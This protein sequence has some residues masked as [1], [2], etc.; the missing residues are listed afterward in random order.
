MLSIRKVSIKSANYY[1]ELAR[2]DYYLSGGEPPGQWHG[3]GAASLGLEGAVTSAQ[4]ENL[5]QG[6][7]PDGKTALVQNAGQ[8]GGYHERVPGWDLTFSP[9]K[10]VSVCWAMATDDVRRAIERAQDQ[11]VRTAL[12]FMEDFAGFTRRGPGGK[13]CEKAT[14]CYALFE[15]GTS[16]AQEPQLHHHVIC[17]N[18]A[19]RSDGTTGAVRSQAL[20]DFRMAV[21]YI[22]SCELAFLL[23]RDVHLPIK[24]VD[25]WFEIDGVSPEVIDRYSTRR[26]EVVAYC[27]ERGKYGAVEAQEAAIATRKPKEHIARDVL[28]RQWQANGEELGWGQEQMMKL[29]QGPGIVRDRT[30]EMAL[31]TQ[32]IRN[33]MAGNPAKWTKAEVIELVARAAQ[34]SELSARQIL[35]AIYRA[36]P[37]FARASLSPLEPEQHAEFTAALKAARK[38][39]REDVTAKRD[40][41]LL[42]GDLEERLEKA[43]KEAQRN[44][45]TAE[46]KKDQP[47]DQEKV[48]DK[49]QD[50]S[51]DPAQDKTHEQ[52]EEKA[53]QKKDQPKDQEKVK[54]KPQDKSQGTAQDKTREQTEEKAEGKAKEEEKARRKRSRGQKAKRPKQAKKAKRSKQRRSPFAIFRIRERTP[55]RGPPRWAID[56]RF[57]SVEV[58][59]KRVF[60]RAWE[61]NPASKLRFPAL[62]ITPDRDPLGL[63][64]RFTIPL[65]RTRARVLGKI[66]EVIRDTFA[67]GVR[68]ILFIDDRLGSSSLDDGGW[69]SGSKRLFRS[70]VVIAKSV[71]RVWRALI[72]DWVRNGLK[73]PEDSLILTQTR[74]KA[75]ILNRI[76][77]Q[78]RKKG[79]KIGKKRHMIGGCAVHDNDRII[80][81]SGNRTYG[82]EPKDVG[83]VTKINSVLIRVLLDN[84]KTVEVPVKSRPSI[85]LAYAL[86]HQDAE[87][88][89]TRRAQILFE[90]ND[91]AREMASILKQREKTPVRIYA[92][93]ENAE[94]FTT[95]GFA[96]TRNQFREESKADRDQEETR[97]A[98]RRE[99]EKKRAEDERR[100]EEKRREEE[101]LRRNREQANSQ[102]HSHGHSH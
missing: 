29:R 31:L 52:T 6:F 9:P 98:E 87:K 94:F 19:I 4:F 47:K 53:E 70:Q 10:S 102:S 24:K 40:A 21:G 11:A 63:K 2:E 76:T 20:Y 58:R 57:F 51:Q 101:E 23:K 48:N 5:F 56:L 34:D 66:G 22:H 89:K 90:A 67:A 49:P 7:S 44:A 59:N 80:F 81:R 60:P 38:N 50:K 88:A 65:D 39:A 78:M 100:R 62:V 12:T 99:E 86:A 74:I 75:D 1:M 64:R 55:R 79:G 33:A 61:C 16:R 13:I 8:K 18:L 37:K 41:E 85:E 84:G 96:R 69:D 77:Q 15:H 27:D 17:L 35:A 91:S 25:R 54:D 36:E 45:E 82:T 97:R 83:T 46:Q 72:K 42:L 3:E 32:C 95:E 93:E 26:K 43:F 30:T 14:F 71:G 68:R 92:M 73:Y 28:V